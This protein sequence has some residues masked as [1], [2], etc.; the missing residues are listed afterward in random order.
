[1][2]VCNIFLR[3][4]G[5]VVIAT[6]LYA[7]KDNNSPPLSP[8]PPVADFDKN[9][10]GTSVPVVANASVALY[11][12]S[13]G[14]RSIVQTS[15]TA[16]N[17][18]YIF[19]VPNT[20]GPIAI[21]INGANNQSTIDSYTSGATSFPFRDTDEICTVVNVG[22][23][24]EL[25]NIVVSY[26]THIVYGLYGFLL[27]VGV[28]DLTAINQANTRIGALLSDNELPN[29]VSSSFA[30]RITLGGIMTYADYLRTLPN[31]SNY[32]T[33]DFIDDISMDV[34]FDGVINLIVCAT[35]SLNAYITKSSFR[36]EVASN[37][38]AYNATLLNNSLAVKT[39][40]TR[41][42]D[43]TDAMYAN[44]PI[45][46][47]SDIESVITNVS[48]QNN[49][50]IFKTTILS[51]NITDIIGISDVSFSLDSNPLEYSLS[52]D[53]Y[54]FYLETID[55]V[56]GPYTFNIAVTN[57]IGVVTELYI[58][59]TIVNNKTLITNFKPT[60]GSYQSGGFIL[61][62]NVTDAYLPITKVEYLENSVVASDRSLSLSSPVMF[63]DSN[64]F[65]DGPRLFGFQAT[66]DAKNTVT[67]QITIIIDN[68][69]PVVDLSTLSGGDVI[70]GMYTFNYST[71]DNTKLDRL[72][73]LLDGTQIGVL[74]NQL[75][76]PAGSN[77]GGALYYDST[78]KA[79]GWYPIL[80][81]AQDAAGNMG[82]TDII[83]IGFDN[84]NPNLDIVSPTPNQVVNATFT[85]TANVDDA[86]GIK[87]IEV[88]MQDVATGDEAHIAFLS[89]GDPT[90]TFTTGLI[91]DGE[92][93][94]TVIV[95]D[96]VSHTVQKNVMFTIKKL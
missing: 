36:H 9:L 44:N 60:D 37:M 77:L 33:L 93:V 87:D 71:T 32:S 38:F 15:T 69:K 20:I 12:L 22:I 49:Q 5:L 96:L 63:T 84:M 17:G 18:G 29:R 75:D 34:S 21:C 92:K 50:A 51:A 76:P 90:R 28:D 7:C 25:E 39:L 65:S 40:A 78:N 23:K 31:N 6:L 57:I 43:S 46:D 83:N 66:N 72:E 42:N 48:V 35:C 13:N 4:I 1:M 16:N 10:F 62:A 70:T 56:D 86:V 58:P 68:T 26:L 94:I 95:R 82:K 24:T 85:V 79:D 30:L 52:L 11:S 74:T 8:T 91:T 45:I 67:G 53:N 19:R 27:T 2:M 89:I 88:R 81:L 59:L 64:Q 61:S 54:S 80:V 73:L 55:Y 3:F 41:W 14:I 47:F